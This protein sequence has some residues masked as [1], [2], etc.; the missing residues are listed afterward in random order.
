MESKIK[1]FIFFV[2]TVFILGGCAVFKGNQL[3]DVGQFQS[4]NAKNQKIDASYDF[5]YYIDV[6]SK[7]EI[8]EKHRKPLENEFIEVMEE[9]GLFSTLTKGKGSSDIH[10]D[11]RLIRNGSPIGILG[12]A[13]TG[14]SLWTIPSWITINHEFSADVTMPNYNVKHYNLTDTTKFVQWLPM[15]FFAYTL[16]NNVEGET[17][18]NIYKNFILKIQNDQ[19][20]YAKNKSSVGSYVS[21]GDGSVEEK[22]DY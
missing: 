7:Q 14:A 17:R 4:T 9:S 13:I 20:L 21:G 3:P 19:S 10:I 18:K 1:F 16:A 15:I 6:F 12:G 2:F 22:W 5:S 11:A 8:S